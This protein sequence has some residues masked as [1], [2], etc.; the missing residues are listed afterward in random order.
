MPGLSFS[1][2]PNL[3]FYSVRVY[4]N[5]MFNYRKRRTS[6]DWFLLCL[7][8]LAIKDGLEVFMVFL[9][10]SLYKHKEPGR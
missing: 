4:R 1:T 6:L 8:I 9:F 7:G 3:C 10:Y 2:L 5:F